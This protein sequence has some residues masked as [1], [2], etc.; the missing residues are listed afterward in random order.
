[1]YACSPPCRIGKR[2]MRRAGRGECEAA[3]LQEKTAPAIPSSNSTRRHPVEP[4]R[5]SWRTLTR[6][7]LLG[8]AG[9]VSRFTQRSLQTGCVTLDVV[10]GLARANGPCRRVEVT[11]WMW[12][13]FMDSRFAHLILAIGLTAGSMFVLLTGHPAK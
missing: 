4:F 3:H 11:M 12:N 7:G 2:R 1:M 6:A 13:R 5:R 8:R 10:E 9:N